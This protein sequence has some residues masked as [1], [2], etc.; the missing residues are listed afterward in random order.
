MSDPVPFRSHLRAIVRSQALRVVAEPRAAD[1][2]Q[3]RLLAWAVL[4]SARG[5]LVQ[6]HRLKAASAPV[7]PSATFRNHAEE[8]AALTAGRYDPWV[9]LRGIVS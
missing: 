9:E 6:Q 8:I 1:T 4:K 3:T 7:P 2:P 5:Q